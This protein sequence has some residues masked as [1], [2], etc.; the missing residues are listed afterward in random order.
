M[1]EFIALR[2]KVYAYLMEDNSEHK[3]AKG[4]KKCVIKRELIFE[5]YKDS[6]FNDKIILKSQQR[7]KSN[8]HKF[9]TEEI[10]KVALSSNDDK[11]LQTFDKITTYP[12]A[13]NAFKVCESEML[14]RQQ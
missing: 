10:N 12:Y 3:K 5:N 7:F 4:T 1:I 2:A 14:N 6:L 13:I 9:Y 11:R 8:H